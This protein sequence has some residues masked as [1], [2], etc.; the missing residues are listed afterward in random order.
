M[1]RKPRQARRKRYLHF[2]DVIT[3]IFIKSEY[4]DNDG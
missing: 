2:K 3:D 4:N 1:L